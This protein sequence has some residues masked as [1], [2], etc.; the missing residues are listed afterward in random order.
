VDE[1]YGEP[2]GVVKQIPKVT[3][4]SLKVPVQPVKTAELILV[5][6]AR[7]WLYDWNDGAHPFPD[8]GAIWENDVVG[9][10]IVGIEI[11]GPVSVI[12]SF[13]STVPFRF[14]GTTAEIKTNDKIVFLQG[15]VEIRDDILAANPAKISGEGTVVIGK[16][17]NLEGALT[18]ASPATL[19]IQDAKVEV[20]NA[21]LL[22]VAS[23]AT[24]SI[25]ENGTVDA[26]EY[27]GLAGAGAIEVEKKG[28]LQLLD[29]ST[30]FAAFTGITA[31]AQI[32]VKSG[33]K[34]L[35]GDKKYV[36]ATG[37]KSDF[38]LGTDA[39]L[40][41][42]ITGSGPE[43]SIGDGKVT[44][45]GDGYVVIGYP[46]TVLGPHPAEGVT[47]GT[48]IVD[49]NTTLGIVSGAAATVLTIEDG[50]AVTVKGGLNLETMVSSPSKVVVEGTLDLKA[51][52]KL[53]ATTGD[54]PKVPCVGE[55]EV[56]SIGTLLMPSFTRSSDGLPTVPFA[57][58]G[59]NSKITIESG[60]LW[61]QGSLNYVGGP[62]S[63]SDFELAA[64]ATL[65]VKMVAL[66]TY[67]AKADLYGMLAAL[68]PAP[69]NIPEFTLTG[70]AYIVGGDSTKHVWIYFPFIID[71][72]DT[73]DTD[74]VLTVDAKT[75][76]SISGL[77]DLTGEGTEYHG[78]VK[79]HGTVEMLNYSK[80]PP[81]ETPTYLGDILPEDG[82]DLSDPTASENWSGKLPKLFDDMDIT[83]ISLFT[84]T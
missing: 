51:P 75:I 38:E 10:K 4:P 50:A 21:G 30:G 8:A 41:I 48:L 40:S 31:G 37:S 33:G 73:G 14:T 27:N 79:N 13:T 29:A 60:G 83:D 62:D 42:A 68:D 69:T 15:G 32:T 39:W 5:M 6:L 64:D 35:M 1:K 24:L 47:A 22:T 17:S 77:L 9:S 52:L 76:L 67:V 43:F 12:E 49:T 36:G 66:T 78:K 45:V 28:T 16:N 81:P 44:A 3:A 25:N 23:G 11:K 80:P 74:M 53:S 70:S 57:D 19:V 26:K 59:G 55:L 65:V 2:V 54:N 71:T 61:K 46:F 63:G 84:E 82:Y 34:L 58:M 20:K 56:S 72:T 18:V 7:N